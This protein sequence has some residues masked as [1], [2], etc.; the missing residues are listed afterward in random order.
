M[1]SGVERSSNARLVSQ[2][3]MMPVA[4]AND[5]MTG[6]ISVAASTRGTTR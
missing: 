4:M 3:V 2:P 6:N 1:K 5:T